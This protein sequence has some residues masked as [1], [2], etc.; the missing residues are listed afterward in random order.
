MHHFFSL[1]FHNISSCHNFLCHLFMHRGVYSFMASSNSKINGL[2]TWK[3][4]KIMLFYFH[5]G[6][7]QPLYWETSEKKRSKNCKKKSWKALQIVLRI[8]TLNI[9]V[10]YVFMKHFA[11]EYIKTKEKHLPLLNGS[12]ATFPLR[13]NSILFE[14]L[15]ESVWL[16]M[17]IRASRSQYKFSQ[18]ST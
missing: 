8:Y 3:V 13:R 2:S 10:V 11:F 14:N 6:Y 17:S 4:K 5:H 12:L 1:I 18:W 16:T 9:Q 15:V 7:I